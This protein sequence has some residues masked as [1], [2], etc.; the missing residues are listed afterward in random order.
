MTGSPPT[1]EQKTTA[2]YETPI[3]AGESTVGQERRPALADAS[4]SKAG[5][6]DHLLEL[7]AGLHRENLELAAKLGF[8]M[9]RVDELERTHTVLPVPPALPPAPRRRWA[10]WRA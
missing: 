5:E 10:F 9:A 7:L 4:L 2:E 6:L 1:Q 3:P 8:Y